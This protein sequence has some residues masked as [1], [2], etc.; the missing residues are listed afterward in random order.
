[1][2]INPK[3]T[4]LGLLIPLTFWLT[5]LIAAYLTPN[6]Q[7]LIH[8]VSQLAIINNQAGFIFNIGLI[9]TGFFCLAFSFILLSL[10]HRNKISIWPITLIILHGLSLIGVGYYPLPHPAHQ[11]WGSISLL[12]IFSPILGIILWSQSQHKHLRLFFLISIS[13]M[14]FGFSLYFPNFLTEYVGLKQ[15]IFHLG[16]SIWYIYLSLPK[17]KS[18]SIDSH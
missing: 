18:F 4:Y 16:W 17:L 14:I 7:G 13:L 6:Y 15:R 5:L 1:M 12:I 2:H 9:I 10:Y 11:W 8:L 3:L